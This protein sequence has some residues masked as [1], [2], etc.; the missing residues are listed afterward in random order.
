MHAIY[1]GLTKALYELWKKLFWSRSNKNCV[2]AVNDRLDKITPIR[3]MHKNSTKWSTK[4]KIKGK[5]L[6]NWLLIY[7][8]PVCLDLLPLEIL[9][10][11][12]LLINATYTFSKSTITRDDID[13]SEDELYVYVAN[14]G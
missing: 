7:S 1:L 6:R 12:A 8:I 4:D 14:Y 10:H 3:E 9:E 2:Q 13:E 5:D 11:H